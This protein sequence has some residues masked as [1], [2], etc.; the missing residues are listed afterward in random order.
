M[1]MKI[2]FST[3][4]GLASGVIIIAIGIISTDGNLYWFANGIALLIVLGGTFSATLVNYSIKNVLGLYNVLKNVFTSESYDYHS[5]IKDI[6]IIA[7]KA[8]KKG[9]HSLEDDLNKIDEKFLR[10]GIELA[11][12]ERDT[13]RLRTFLSLEMDN[14]ARRHNSV[15]EIF[16]YMGSYAPAFGM[17]GTIM[18]LII[19]M[20]SFSGAESL[21]QIETI[22]FDIAEKF[23]TL[24]GGMGM[25]LITTFYGVLFSN[26]VFLPIGGKLKRKSEDELMLRNIILEGIMSIHAKEHP[27]LIQEKLMTFVQ[28]S[29][30]TVK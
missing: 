25:A 10:K 17:L 20:K 16:F 5:V 4:F 30:R 22:D 14:I 13:K 3:A 6:V 28:E 12:N 24:L 9:V 27:I 15:Q 26:L 1:K 2:D 8:R 23:A 29:K 21:D 18:G 11:I 7:D 19:M